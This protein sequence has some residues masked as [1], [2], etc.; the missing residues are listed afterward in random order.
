M[1]SKLKILQVNKFFYPKGGSETHLRELID[2]LR[3]QGHEVAEFSMKHPLNW[4]SD[5]KKHFV[6][7]IDY[8]T[9]F[10]AEKIRY[11][12]K[13]IYSAEA[14][15]KITAVL[16]RFRPDVVHLHLFQHQL[17]PSILPEIRKRGIPVVYTVHDLKPVCPN[18]KML[19]HGTVCEKCLHGRYI[20]CLLNRCTKDSYPKSLLNTVEMYFHRWR[21]YY[22]L[23]DVFLTPSDFHRR[24]LIEGGYPGEKIIHIPN[25]V[26]AGQFVPHYENAGYLVYFGRLSDEKG[27]KTL[28]D[29]MKGPGNTGQLYIIGTGPMRGELERRAA[30]TGLRHVRFLGFKEKDELKA[31]VS[32]AMFTVIPSEC[33]ENAP[34]SLLESF[35]MGKPAVVSNIGGVP[36][37]VSPSEDG[38][39]CQPG[40]AADLREKILQMSRSQ[41]RLADMGRKARKKVETVYSASVQVRNIVKVY[42]SLIMSR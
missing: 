32:N 5:W 25:F 7:T 8:E 14:G 17:S 13:V 27:L 3:S 12:S 20:H 39:I 40:N 9:P 37:Y 11:A 35:A 38:L 10:L 16:D 21:K 41:E 22:D 30:E 19:S 6:D 15:R 24:K 28:L 1:L 2:G 23:I 34:M 42:E 4:D 36:E 33:Y 18:Y 31:L 26:N 29:A